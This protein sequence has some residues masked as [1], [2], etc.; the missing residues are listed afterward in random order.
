M[1]AGVDI[2]FRGTDFSQAL[3]EKI[4]K[5]LQKLN[6]YTDKI[7]NSRVVI[8]TPHKNKLKGNYYRASIELG[9]SGE[10][11]VAVK[12][13]DSIHIAVRDAFNI[14]ERKIKKLATKD[15]RGRYVAPLELVE[16]T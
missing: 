12:D 5:K 4:T 9:L 8:E 13:D 14:V 10:T 2:I 15:R 7:L 3:N 11:V 16:S 6:R 1:K